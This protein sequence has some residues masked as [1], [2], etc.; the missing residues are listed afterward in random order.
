MMTMVMNYDDYDDDCD[1]DD[2]D[3]NW[4]VTKS[5]LTAHHNDD[6][7]SDDYED[8]SCKLE[9]K[10]DGYILN[11]FFATY[12]CLLFLFIQDDPDMIPLRGVDAPEREF[13]QFK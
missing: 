6:N 4:Q 10:L 11:I 12:F 2:D 3:D 1:D 8:C 5:L 13:K 9:Y 7:G